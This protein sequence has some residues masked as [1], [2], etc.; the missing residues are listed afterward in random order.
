MELHYPT[1][2][3]FQI[4]Q[5]VLNSSLLMVVV[6][7]GSSQSIAEIIL[8][9]KHKND[10]AG[11]E[12]SDLAKERLSQI[13]DKYYMANLWARGILEVQHFGMA[14]S[15][16]HV[17]VVAKNAVRS[18]TSCEPKALGTPRGFVHVI[19]ANGSHRGVHCV[20]GRRRQ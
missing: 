1:A 14:F 6:K 18:Q 19:R 13:W 11:D 17:K 12:L 10:V 9:P 7:R 15:G 8:E 20:C 2:C 5:L 3:G 16:W 4:G